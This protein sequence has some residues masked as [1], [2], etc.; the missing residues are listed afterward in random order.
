MK[1]TANQAIAT[2]NYQS[3]FVKLE[4]FIPT[5]T[6]QKTCFLLLYYFRMVVTI[7]KVAKNFPCYSK[8]FILDVA[9]FIEFDIE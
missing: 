3:Y 2:D 5:R 8:K 6:D 4:I 1:L 9:R 7:F